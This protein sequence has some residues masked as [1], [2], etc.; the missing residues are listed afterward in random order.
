MSGQIVVSSSGANVSA[1]APGL[2]SPAPASGARLRPDA[3]VCAS[4]VSGTV[5]TPSASKA[6][7]RAT[8]ADLD[9][10]VEATLQHIH[11]DATPLPDACDLSATGARMVQ[12][13]GGEWWRAAAP[14]QKPQS[15]PVTLPDQWAL[16]GGD[17]FS[18]GGNVW[19]SKRF[20]VDDATIAAGRSTRL[21]FDS[22]DHAADVYLNGK[23]IGHHEGYAEPF[24]IDVR[25]L[26][27]TDRPNLLA[28]KVSTPLDPGAPL[29]KEQ[30]KGVHGQHDS[31][32]ATTMP[33]SLAGASNLGTTGGLLGDVS[34]ISTG[35]ARVSTTAVK[36]TLE[37]DGKRARL[38]FTHR[39]FNDAAPRDVTVEVMWHPAGDHE[40]SRV[41]RVARTVTL[42]KGSSTVRLDGVEPDARL[43]WTHDLG[44][45][46]LYEME[47]RVIEADG[48]VSDARTQRFGIREL[49]YDEKTAR[50]SLN[51]V[52]I[53]QRGINFVAAEWLST[54][55]AAGYTADLAAMRGLGLNAVRVH[56]SV[57]PDSFYDAAD[58][59]GMLVW[60]DF[61]L[62]WG[63][64]TSRAFADKASAQAQGFVERL[65]HHPS[66]WTWCMH[67][68]PFPQNASLDARLASEVRKL[69]DT[70]PTMKESS[71]FT[72][73]YP[74]WYPGFPYDYRGI[75]RYAPAIASE[76]GPQG[77]A[78]SMRDVAGA[79]WP[80]DRAAWAFHNAQF[81]PLEHHVGAVAEFSS[82]DAF[83]DASQQYQADSLRYITE[84]LRRRKYAPTSMA[85]PYAFRDPWPSV[86]WGVI[87][88]EGAPKEAFHALRASM[89]PVLLS[90]D[91]VQNRFHAGDNVEVPLW[92]VNDTHVAVGETVEWSVRRRGAPG[93]VLQRGS[94]PAQVPGDGAVELA[95]AR[96]TVPPNACASEQFVLWATLR[97]GQGRPLADTHYFFGVQGASSKR[98]EAAYLPHDEE[99]ALRRRV[100]GEAPTASA[101]APGAAPAPGTAPAPGVPPTPGAAPAPGAPPTPGT[102]PASS[103]SGPISC[104]PPAD[105][106]TG[107]AA[108]VTWLLGRGAQGFQIEVPT[109]TSVVTQEDVRRL[110]SELVPG[111]VVM[112]AEN[113]YPA[114]QDVTHTLLGVDYTHVLMY[115][116]D[117]V[118]YESNV[119]GLGG[120]G[121]TRFSLE[122][123]VGRPIL[124]EA[125]RPP[126]ASADDVT[127]ALAY[128]EDRVGAPY[129]Y[130]FDLRSDQAV[131][132]TELVA[133]A[134]RAG[135]NPLDVPHVTR[136]GREGVS[137]D[138]F[139]RMKGATVVHSDGS[140]YA[141]NV[142]SRFPVLV[143]GFVGAT[144]A[145]VILGPLAAP[146][147]WVGGMTLGIAAGNVAMRRRE[148]KP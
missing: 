101:P 62:H 29:F 130:R 107:A 58:E 66:V 134:L 71:F 20:V 63:Q 80:P 48:T 53:F 37:G 22:V 146:A 122:Q 5:P 13:L 10:R 35:P 117:G 69:D 68:E 104:P 55:D 3:S 36:T 102:A 19:Y 77:I 120:E 147:G 129:D 103:P 14:K 113:C 72:H 33:A 18:Y 56:A 67:N 65:Q 105:P 75:R 82:V 94:A 145:A 88:S 115:A 54:I 95:Q 74:G 30:I 34:L 109:V 50:L 9:A 86:G 110:R 123:L 47:T 99:E 114:L 27:R 61:P 108:F 24:E 126:Y 31:R 16:A 23:H 100:E 121:C 106:Q 7:L 143:S 42:P 43:W 21:C 78:A 25:G 138:A 118:C 135:P 137:I 4:A 44:P 136:L 148:E 141:R 39:L 51:G 128:C 1:S 127:A 125:V 89:A 28:V 83:I 97:D 116:G 12:H 49:R 98:Y 111:D 57:L 90:A 15:A 92:G 96:F 81:D 119:R 46:P 79:T 84:Y 132:C 133:N 73:F 8:P 45:S 85:Y 131:Y 76:Y 140:R 6:S 40:P 59:A 32:P 112:V 11:R 124:F 60:A 38:A 64:S 17:L 93:V 41:H 70:R 142:L 87:D 139:A 144:T 52:P 26:L 2:R 91:W